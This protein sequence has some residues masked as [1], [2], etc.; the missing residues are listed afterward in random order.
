LFDRGIFY[1][2]SVLW[3]LGEK[4]DRAFDWITLLDQRDKM[5]ISSSAR[6]SKIM[7]PSRAAPR[8]SRLPSQDEITKSISKNNG[9]NSSST[10]KAA[11]IRSPRISNAPLVTA[12]PEVL[13]SVGLTY[14]P[15]LIP[16]VNNKQIRTSHLK[17][18][19][20]A[21]TQKKKGWLSFCFCD[22]RAQD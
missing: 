6:N 18:D 7:I 12:K 11:N 3:K 4:D 16:L 5:P 15:T 22:G 1:F 20:M 10:N 19:G 21:K 17:V 8:R 2:Y 13:E 14:S 9:I